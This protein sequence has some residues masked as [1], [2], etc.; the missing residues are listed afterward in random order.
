MVMTPAE[1]R[2]QFDTLV[3]REYSS[4]ISAVKDDAPY[5]DQTYGETLLPR[6][7]RNSDTAR[8]AIAPPL[9]YNAVENVA[10]HILLS[11]RISVPARLVVEGDREAQDVAERKRKALRLWWEH[12]A[13]YGGDP[14]SVAVKRLIKDGK[15]VLKVTLRWDLLPDDADTAFAA[16]GLDEFLWEV[17]A[18][19]PETVFEEPGK[20]HD[21]GYVYEAFRVFVGD[22]KHI[23]PKATGSWASAP[24][25]ERVERIEYWE[26]PRANSKGRYLVWINDEVVVDE[27]NPYHWETARSTRR[28]RDYTG[29]LPYHIRPSGWGEVTATS[30]PSKLY[31]GILRRNHSVMDAV[32]VQATNA[33]VQLAL[34]TFPVVLTTGLPE[35]KEI[36]I[37]PGKK[38]A[39]ATAEETVQFI[40][41]PQLPDGT[42]SLLAQ[43]TQWSNDL[44][45]FGALG[46]VPLR[47][48]DTATEADTVVRNATAKL[49]H[50]LNAVRAVVMAVNRQILQDIEHLILQPVSL[51][52]S[53][54]G[55]GAEVTI[56]PEDIDGFYA[57]AVEMTTSAQVAL[58]RA[59]SRLWMDAYVRLPGLSAETVLERMGVEDPTGEQKARA[60]EEAARHPM[61]QQLYTLLALASLGPAAESVR[62]AL[63]AQIAQGAT[64]T[65]AGGG[66]GDELSA[67]AT[68]PP[69]GSAAIRA[70]QQQARLMRPDL[71]NQ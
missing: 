26:K 1:L 42:F 63:A 13:A 6:E 33:H 54:G 57:N 16:L 11:P 47:G 51:F 10:D 39:V 8:L 2:A 50:P 55:N 32:A 36:T 12:I 7:W 22:A 15:L 53:L 71:E 34:A 44:T 35:S 49:H 9:G 40:P 25:H 45:K 66:G 56:S 59:E 61:M 19:P 52:G 65:P 31:V 70:G 68:T 14:L 37:G 62:S 38:I 29:Y 30:D 43:T 20:R 3:H 27:V 5:Y 41:W 17:A 58:D 46:G 69:P 21:P 4:Y 24:P 48:V 28:K 60:A 18:P 23:Y 67:A 64:V